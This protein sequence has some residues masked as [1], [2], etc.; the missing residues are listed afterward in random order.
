MCEQSFSNEIDVKI[1]S[2]NV[3]RNVF[4]KQKGENRKKYFLGRSFLQTFVLEFVAMG[5]D[6]NDDKKL[7]PKF[8]KEMF[9]K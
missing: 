7:K 5:V 3:H 9:S 2:K 4:R 1:L 8:R 6:R